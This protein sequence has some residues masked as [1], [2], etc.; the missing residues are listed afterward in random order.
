MLYAGKVTLCDHW[1]GKFLDKIKEMGLYDNSLIIFTTDHGAPFGEHGYIKKAQP[2]LHEDLVRIP[3]II[4][5]PDGIGA[6][7]RKKAL[8]ETTEIFPTIL[9]FLNQRIPPKVHGKSLLPLMS[10]ELDSIRDYAYCGHFKRNWRVSDHEWAFTL[11]FDKGKED[12]LYNLK[13]DPLEQDNLINKEP[14]KAMELEL[15]LRRFVAG[16]K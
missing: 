7:E 5:H 2:G 9:D 10:G 13:E 14:T 6:G 12:E 4:R 8:V 3:L 16:L 1:L 15:E 11:N